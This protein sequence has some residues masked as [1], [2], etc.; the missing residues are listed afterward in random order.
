MNTCI[1]MQQPYLSIIVPAYNE[2]KRLPK[3]LAALDKQLQSVRFSYEIL[4]VNDGSHD[5]TASIVTAMA[6]HIKNL[7]LLSFEKN[8]GKGGAVRRGMLHA[9]GTIRLFTDADNATSIDHFQKMIPLFDK[10]YSVI[11]GSRTM[12]ESTLSPPESFPRQIIGRVLNM[13]VQI[14]VLPGV[15]DTQCGFKAFT[16]DAAERIFSQ[17][18]T[19][20]WGF[21]VEILAL[22]KKMNYMIQE[23]PVYWV[24]GDNSTVG[25]SAGPKFIIDILKIRWSLWAGQYEAQKPYNLYMNRVV[26]TR[27]SGVG[28]S[29]IPGSFGR[30]MSNHSYADDVEDFVSTVG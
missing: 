16:A 29:P 7:K 18:R 24:N 22:A 14:L 8:S 6:S 13:F 2:A 20:G 15:W 23:I 3:T 9:Q 30:S 12:K 25:L 27:Y 1:H 10:G 17:T 4:V 5:D 19:F 26:P 11:I 21:D 28:T